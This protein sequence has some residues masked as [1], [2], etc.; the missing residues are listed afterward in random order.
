[1]Y[2]GLCVWGEGN[3][4]FVVE[5]KG[6]RRIVANGENLVRKELQGAAKNEA[7][8]ETGRMMK[9]RRARLVGATIKVKEDNGQNNPL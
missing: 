3:R 5:F 7:E 2:F 8:I 1:M 6:R 4:A 9:K